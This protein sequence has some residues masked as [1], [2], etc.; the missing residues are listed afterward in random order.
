MQGTLRASL[1]L[2]QQYFYLILLAKRV[3]WPNPKPRA[4]AMRPQ[5]K[6]TPKLR[7]ER[8]GTEICRIWYRNKYQSQNNSPGRKHSSFQTPLYS[9]KPPRRQAPPSPR[10]QAPLLCSQ[11]TGIHRRGHTKPQTPGLLPPP[12]DYD[13]L[14]PVISTFRSVK[15]YYNPFDL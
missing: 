13:P 12:I 14:R 5:W 1:A 8:Y 2:T 10:V 6:A 15:T 3:T 7:G 11:M 9:P 4:R